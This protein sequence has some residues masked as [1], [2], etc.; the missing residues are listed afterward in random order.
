MLAVLAV[1]QLVNIASGSVGLLLNMCGQQVTAFWC[2]VFSSILLVCTSFALIP[3]FGG[4][5]AAIAQTLSVISCMVCLSVI[6]WRTLGFAPA[7][8][9]KLNGY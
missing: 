8:G 9:L 5:G 2:N 6:S 4:V 1:G 7:G 3:V